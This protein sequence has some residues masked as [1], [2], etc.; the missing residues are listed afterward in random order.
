MG[1]VTINHNVLLAK[2]LKSEQ[3]QKQ[4]FEFLN[5][6]VERA[7][8]ELLTEFNQSPVTQE[9]EAGE[10]ASSLVLPQGYGNLFGFLGFDAGREP[11]G[12]VRE[13][14]EKIEITSRKPQV[15]GRTWVFRIIFPSE[16][17][18]EKVSK[19]DWE[20]GR[21][22]INAV[23]KGLS[24]FSHFLSSLKRRLGRSGGGVQVESDLRSS[25]EYFAGTPYVIGMLGR[26]KRKILR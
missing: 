20:S 5:E 21:S 4:A 13:E 10:D 14:L 12:P 9:L 25:G 24:G 7:K 8:D 6:K 19:M 18:L 15:S 1:K 22:W 17:D 3:T 11:I 16:E 2:I 23:T 26:F